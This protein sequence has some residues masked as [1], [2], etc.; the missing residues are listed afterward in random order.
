MKR[1]VV[2]RLALVLFFLFA[3]VLVS[4]AVE[5]SLNFIVNAVASVI[6]IVSAV[7]YVSLGGE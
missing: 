4:N 7:V 5:D 3:L 2:S 1:E 6:T